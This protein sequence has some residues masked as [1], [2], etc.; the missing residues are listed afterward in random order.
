MAITI[1]LPSDLEREL[2]QRIPDLD[3]AA[4]E[5]FVVASYQR[6]EL[7][8]GDVAEILSLPTRAE[9]CRWLRERGVA[10]NYSLDD[11]EQDR[12]QLDELID[13]QR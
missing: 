13:P 3:R 2:R 8:V 4:R 12:H 6:G 9:A 5:H 1:Q 10:M 11:L 7:S